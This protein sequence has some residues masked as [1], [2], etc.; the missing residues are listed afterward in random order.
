[1]SDGEGT[2]AVAGALFLAG[3]ATGIA[4]YTSIKRKY[5][6]MAAR[7]RP[8]QV[9][10]YRVLN[11]TPL[12]AADNTTLATQYQIVFECWA[13]SYAIALSTAAAVRAAIAASA[14]N[15]YAVDEPGEEYEAAADSFMEPVYFGFLA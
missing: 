14:L 8:D 11:K 1:M 5:R 10:N 9:V 6:N 4:I 13:T 7:Y 3:P 15:F 12:L 2:L